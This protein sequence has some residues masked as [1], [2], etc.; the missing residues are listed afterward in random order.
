MAKKMIASTPK[1]LA[2]LKYQENV[3]EVKADETVEQAAEYFFRNLF[4]DTQAV[5]VNFLFEEDGAKVYEAYKD[6]GSVD[7]LYLI[8]R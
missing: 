7:Y 4:S 6:S 5:K 3:L 8:K 2:S 1:N